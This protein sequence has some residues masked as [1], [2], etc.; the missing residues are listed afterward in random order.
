MSDSMLGLGA[1]VARHRES[2]H[3]S[4]RVGAKGKKLLESF[5]WGGLPGDGLPQA[6]NSFQ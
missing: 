6:V 1:A 4:E 2:I 5:K 3:L